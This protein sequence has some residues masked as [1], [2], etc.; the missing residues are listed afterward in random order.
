M[1][2]FKAFRHAWRNE[3][4]VVLAV[5]TPPAVEATTA[6]PAAHAVLDTVEALPESSDKLD[7]ETAAFC[8]SAEGEAVY[9]GSN[10]G[11]AR[12][13]IEK[14]TSRGVEWE[15][16]RHGEPWCRSPVNVG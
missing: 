10:G 9:I 12:R 11:D 8:V 15:A 13:I 14:L 7:P 4:S 5:S 16:L 1:F 3:E 6:L 2:G